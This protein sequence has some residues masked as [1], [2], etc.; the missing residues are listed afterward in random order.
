[1]KFII[2]WMNAWKDLSSVRICIIFLAD[3]VWQIEIGLQ[4]YR[5]DGGEM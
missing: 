4:K 3:V 1:M 2:R 5:G